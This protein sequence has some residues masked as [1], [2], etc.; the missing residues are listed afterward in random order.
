MDVAKLDRPGGMDGGSREEALFCAAILHR[1]GLPVDYA[2]MESET[3]PK[4]CVCC[5]APLQ[6]LALPG[7]RMDI[8]FAWQ[9]HLGRC[10]GDGRR[11][12]AHDVG[13]R[14]LKEL[15][16]SNPNPGGAAFPDSSILI[17][18]AHLR[19]D[20][21]RPGDIMALGRDV[22]RLDTAMGIVIASGLT[23]SCLTFS[24]KSSD[25]V[26]KATEKAKVREGQKISQSH[27]VLFHDALCSSGLEPLWNEGPSL[28]GSYQGTCHN[29]GDK[30]G[31]MLS[32]TRPFCS[33][34]YRSSSQDPY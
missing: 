2:K 5:K 22:H 14:A 33:H 32:P 16:L 26:L 30:A 11:L 18:P 8:L 34:S 4:M 17:E 29:R 13:K 23:K 6:D 3:L 12:Q 15:V 24:C 20:I 28:S 7:T 27:L 9:C 21:S 31:R 25:F 1:Y 10:G 19:E